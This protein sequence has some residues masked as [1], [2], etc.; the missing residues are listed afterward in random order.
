MAADVGVFNAPPFPLAQ[1]QPVITA[2]LAKKARR[3]TAEAIAFEVARHALETD[4]GL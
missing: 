1:F 4:L 3:A 2:A